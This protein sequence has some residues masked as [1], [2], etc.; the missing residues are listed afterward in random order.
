MKN[1]IKNESEECNDP[2]CE[3]CGDSGQH[4]QDMHQD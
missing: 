1:E 4:L 2:N 3:E